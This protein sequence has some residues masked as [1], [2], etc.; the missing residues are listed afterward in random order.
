MGY[1]F[2]VVA[3]LTSEPWAENGMRSCGCCSCRALLFVSY[4]P[5]CAVA[6]VSVTQV[7]CSGDSNDAGG[8]K[9]TIAG[10]TFRNN[11][12]LELGGG[13]VAWGTPTVVTITGGEFINNSAK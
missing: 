3:G 11:S 9:V 4:R 7:Y 8:S 13:I 10:G 6:F 1:T 5:R 12:A 2:E